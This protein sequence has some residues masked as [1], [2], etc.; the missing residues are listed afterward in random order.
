MEGESYSS[1]EIEGEVEIMK[2][3]EFKLRLGP[4]HTQGGTLYSHV[5]ALVHI[6]TTFQY[7]DEPAEV[8][9]ESWGGI[10]D[11]DK[12]K[13]EMELKNLCV[14]YSN[15][16]TV[17]MME[18]SQ[19]TQNFLSE[20]AKPAVE[21][22]SVYDEMMAANKAKVKAQ[23]DEKAKILKE[24]AEKEEERRVIIEEE[25]NRLKEAFEKERKQRK[26]RLMKGNFKV[27][28]DKE[29]NSNSPKR[30]SLRSFSDCS[31]ESDSSE[32]LPTSITF[33]SSEKRELNILRLIKLKERPTQ[34]C[35]VTLGQEV[36]SKELFTLYSWSLKVKKVGKAQDHDYLLDELLTKLNSS[37]KE[38]NSLLKLSHE[39]LVSFEGMKIVRPQNDTMHI[40]ILQEYVNG[41]SLKVYFDV[42]AS[43]SESLIQ[44]VATGVVKALDFLHTNNVVHRDIRDTCVF[45][46]HEYGIVRLADYSIER[47][48]VEAIMEYEGKDLESSYPTSPGRGGKKGDVFRF[49]LLL[50]SLTQGKRI[51][52][53]PPNIPSKLGSKF[54][55]FLSFCLDISDHERWSAHQL[56]EHPFIVS[57]APEEDSGRKEIQENICINFCLENNGNEN[58]LDEKK[59]EK[60]LPKCS[61]E[62]PSNLKACSRFLM[63][64]DLI[65]MLGKGGFG[66]VYKVRNKVD[67]RIYALKRIS[68]Y[69][70]SEATRRKMTREVKLLSSLNHEN[71]VRLSNNDD[72][73]EDILF[74][75]SSGCEAP[76]SESDDEVDG[77]GNSNADVTSKH[78]NHVKIGDFGLAT[79]AY[80]DINADNSTLQFDSLS[81]ENMES[82][83]LTGL[84]GTTLYIAPELTNV[85]GK[86]SY[87]NKVDIY[88]LGII[89]FEMFYNFS[90]G[91]ERIKLISLLRSPHPKFPDDFSSERKRKLIIYLLANNP[92]ER[93]STKEL[94]ASP[95]LP[96]PTAEEQKFMAMLD[97]KVKNINSKDYQDIL[98]LLFKQSAR[99][100][101]QA[102]FEFYLYEYK[103]KKLCSKSLLINDYVRNQIASI[104]RSH[105]GIFVPIAFYIPKGTFYENRENSLTLMT[106]GGEMITSQFELRYPFARYIARSDIKRIRRC[107]IDRVQRSVKISGVHPM[108]FYECAFDIIA[109]KYDW[110]ESISRVNIIAQEILL[111]L[112]GFNASEIVLKLGHSDLLKLILNYSGIR[113]EDHEKVLDLLYSYRLQQVNID[114][115]GKCLRSVGIG[116]KSTEILKELYQ[117]EGAVEQ[118]LSM[119]Q[120]KILSSSSR[121]R[122]F[123][124][125]LQNIVSDIKEVKKSLTDIGIQFEIVLQPLM[126]VDHSLYHGISFQLF[127]KNRSKHSTENIL[128]QGGSYEHLITTFRNEIYSKAKRFESSMS[129]VGISLPLKRMI[130][131][132]D[133]K[134]LITSLEDYRHKINQGP[135]NDGLLT[136][137]LFI[138]AVEE[139]Q[140]KERINLVSR[141]AT[142]NI[143][144]DHGFAQVRAE[145]EALSEEYWFIPHFVFLYSDKIILRSKD[146][147]SLDRNT[148]FNDR[149]ISF[150]N[151]FEILCKTCKSGKGAADFESSSSNS[152]KESFKTGVSLKL[153]EISPNVIY[154]LR[155]RMKPKDL[156]KIE[157]TI[158]EEVMSH[159]SRCLNV[160]TSDIIEIYVLEIEKKVLL[161]LGQLD[162]DT[163]VKEFNESTVD[164]YTRFPEIK[165]YLEKIFKAFTNS[166]FY[167]KKSERPSFVFCYSIECFSLFTYFESQSI[168]NFYQFLNY[169]VIDKPIVM[170]YKFHLFFILHYLNCEFKEYI[171]FVRN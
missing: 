78:F 86:V 65:E 75:D 39:N 58:S 29:A 24:E 134:K 72:E 151:M 21:S 9:I 66:H 147:V 107:C 121:H 52:K 41:H 97:A 129:A 47:R 111:K 74:Q 132:L 57:Y 103:K 67:D 7:P 56:V 85:T 25:C 109:P 150:S 34:C 135:S 35:K 138:C 80:K 37:E 62:I 123:G 116:K 22:E 145:A 141:L 28:N 49:G 33:T 77:N 26:E 19:F 157:K 87:T 113:E 44:H 104:F 163:S 15:S 20:H 170:I 142:E 105:G 114:C 23:E 14:E 154:L 161:A 91:M 69:H 146:N 84:V 63:E 158:M 117:I 45:L 106:R 153:E 64:Y 140:L 60:D 4:H 144:A 119:L 98:Q 128:A 18:I 70:K 137:D 46:D 51:K 168:H 102:T 68:L 50:L 83:A 148:H 36:K 12:S 79:V 143:F 155:K 164:I 127:L 96:P 156:M 54:R 48:C 122:D 43:L 2:L 27:D 16:G 93:P 162:F 8:I 81:F 131:G 94:L 118:I 115:L 124:A 38:M 5:F 100:E 30:R 126:V 6:S 71:V 159:I 101:L 73:S 169:F 160:T 31:N 99:S 61:Y 1:S 130:G 90:T 17:V 76:N 95:L 165:D 110:A 120:S 40:H 88:S 112:C 10:T 108:E 3:H 55:D 89:L 53:I 166:I 152:R 139:R 13:L 149:K 82:S 133:S 171:N 125:L 59:K 167:K 42:N 136:T 92:V 11:K 32:T